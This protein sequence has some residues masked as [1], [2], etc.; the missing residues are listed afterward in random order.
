MRY[1][2]AAV[3]WVAQQEP[4]GCVCASFAMILGVGYA[5]AKARFPFGP[6]ADGYYISTTVHRLLKNDGWRLEYRTARKRGGE[7]WPPPPFA[8]IHMATVLVHQDAPCYH[9][10]VMD[11]RGVVFD[12]ISPDPRV[13]AGYVEVQAVVGL[14]PP[15]GLA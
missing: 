11:R 14:T 3:T 13:L 4:K 10:V 15:A 12:P 8:P 6:T 1:D 2:L 7:A 9:S 5:E